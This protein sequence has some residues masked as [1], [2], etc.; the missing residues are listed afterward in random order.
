M[1]KVIY[2]SCTFSMV[3]WIQYKKKSLFLTTKSISERMYCDVIGKISNLLKTPTRDLIS[4]THHDSDYS[5][6]HFKYFCAM[7][8]VTPK[9]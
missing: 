7:G 6:L 1:I 5:F 3:L 8:G 9:R 2:L 4:V